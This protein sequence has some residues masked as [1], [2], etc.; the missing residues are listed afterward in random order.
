MYIREI[1][2]FI[3]TLFGLI[4]MIVYSINFNILN[5]QIKMLKYIIFLGAISAIYEVIFT[6]YL[7]INSDYWFRTYLILEFYS[8]YYFFYKLFPKKKTRNYIKFIGFLFAIYFVFLLKYWN[9]I[10][11][12]ITDSYVSIFTTLFVYLFSI[13]WF[14]KVF[15]NFELESLFHSPIFIVLSGLLLYFSST[16]FLFL[17]SDYFLKDAHYKFLD[18]WQ[19]NVIMCILFRILLLTAILKGKKL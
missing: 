10:D 5:E 14:R 1:L 4:P 3:L 9:V 17:L 13:I 6:V 11:N 12:L 2:F 19:L 8:I 16:L 18:F 7:K 15:V